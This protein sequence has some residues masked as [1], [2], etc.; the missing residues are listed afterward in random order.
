MQSSKQIAKGGYSVVILHKNNKVKKKISMKFIQTALT[1]YFIT[2]VC[3]HPNI[4][5]INKVKCCECNESILL[6]MKK[7]KHCLNN[8]IKNL[9]FAHKIKIL[10]CI[11]S[12][13]E[14]LHNRGFIHG[15]IKLSNILIDNHK[16]AILIDFGLAQPISNEPFHS[17]LQTPY[18]TAPEIKFGNKYLNLTPKI[19]IWTIGMCALYML[20]DNIIKNHRMKDFHTKWEHYY[21]FPSSYKRCDPPHI[22]YIRQLLHLPNNNTKNAIEK[23]LSDNNE[24]NFTEM[25]KSSAFDD[26]IEFV[27]GCTKVNANER[28]DATQ[29]M[30]SIRKCMHK[31]LMG[32]TNNIPLFYKESIYCANI[33]KECVPNNKKPAREN[34]VKTLLL[35]SDDEKKCDEIALLLRDK[36]SDLSIKS[37]DYVNELIEFISNISKKIKESI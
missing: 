4:I 26:L 17:C 10:Y 36:S 19:D 12:A 13:V 16:N 22:E 18:Y 24:N 15:D 9:K 14:Y 5:K 28:F 1:E 23:I 20:N 6:Y 32:T 8:R 25:K 3:D 33:F 21:N 29:A 30:A 37:I 7:Y 35:Y 31:V 11:V 34:I 27:D 2:E